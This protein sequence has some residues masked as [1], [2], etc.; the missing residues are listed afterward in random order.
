MIDSN[1][2]YTCMRY[3]RFRKG[4]N[5]VLSVGRLC[6]LLRRVP[7]RRDWL[8]WSLHTACAGLLETKVHKSA[9]YSWHSTDPWQNAVVKNSRGFLH[10]RMV[11]C[12]W[13]T[14]NFLYKFPSSCKKNKLY[15]FSR[16][17]VF[18]YMSVPGKFWIAFEH[19]R[20]WWK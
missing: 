15:G 7:Q 19:D 10:L 5:F 9:H 17:L 8:L 13:T 4:L 3:L 6:Q 1:S 16:I 14:S 18:C 12:C 2:E 11:G 20:L